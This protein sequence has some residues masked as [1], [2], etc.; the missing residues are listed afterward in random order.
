MTLSDWAGFASAQK[1]LLST[2]HQPLPGL[3]SLE[4]AVRGVLWQSSDQDGVGYL[5][6][7]YAQR[8]NPSGQ[9]P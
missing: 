8:Y 5:F 7:I 4:S 1:Q 6:G 2:S 9:S 3:F